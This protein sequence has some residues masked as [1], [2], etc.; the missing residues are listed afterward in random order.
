MQIVTAGIIEKDGKF[1]IAKRK[2]GKCLGSKWE[3]PGGKLEEGETHEDCLKRELMEELNIDTAIGEFFCSNDF[4]CTDIA[5]RLFAYKAEYISGEIK[6]VDHDEY[7]WVTANEFKNYEFVE[8]DIPIVN[9]LVMLF[10]KI[11]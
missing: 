3:F 2:A 8:P 7:K 10:S 9:K 4:A 5:I 11:S 1:L 6:I